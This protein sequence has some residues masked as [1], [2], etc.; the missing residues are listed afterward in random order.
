MISGNPNIEFDGFDKGGPYYKA[1]TVRGLII[2]EISKGNSFQ[3]RKA[4]AMSEK[5][6][7]ASNAIDDAERIF[8]NALNNLIKSEQRITE[9][10]RKVS[11]NVRQ[12]ANDLASGLKKIEQQANFDRLEKFVVL[13]ERA[14]IAMNHLAELEANGKLEKIAQAI[15]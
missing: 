14:S 13:L 15:R 10:S 3:N 2:T 5:I 4:K 9:S 11:G 8:N 7:E 12:A 6:I 1:S